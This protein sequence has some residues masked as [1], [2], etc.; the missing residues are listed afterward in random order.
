MG[1]L[2]NLLLIDVDGVLTNSEIH[3]NHL[4]EVSKTFHA[5]DSRAI[6]QLVSEGWEVHILSTSGWPG[7]EKYKARSSA[8][9]HSDFLK[10][11]ANLLEVTGGRPYVAIGD[12]VWDLEMLRGAA[13]ALCPSDADTEVKRLGKVVQLGIP[14]GRGVIAEVVRRIDEL[15]AKRDLSG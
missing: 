4:G 1:E 3:V 5:R 2:L 10:T 13:L 8:I 12:D 14:G 7:L 11:E 9:V 6:R 15:L